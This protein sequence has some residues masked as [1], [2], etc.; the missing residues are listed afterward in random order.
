MTTQDLYGILRNYRF[1][2]LSTISPEG[3][4]E[5]ALVGIGVT[6]KLELIFDTLTHTRKCINLRKD[7]HIAFV[8]GWD[9]EISI[10]YEGCADEPEGEELIKLQQDY[11]LA[12]PDG[13]ERQKW[14]GITYFRVRPKW[15]RYSNYNQPPIILEFRSEQLP[16]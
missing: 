11:F 12:F 1:G 6:E 5:A 15:I 8:I 16:S 13:P 7:H 2:V 10:Q 9:H 14:P 3:F 4:P